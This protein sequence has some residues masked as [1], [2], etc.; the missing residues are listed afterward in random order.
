MLL[1]VISMLVAGGVLFLDASSIS[2][3]VVHATGQRIFETPSRPQ[4]LRRAA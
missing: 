2:S 3:T 1:N 4:E